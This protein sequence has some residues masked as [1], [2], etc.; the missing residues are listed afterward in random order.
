MKIKILERQDHFEAVNIKSWG[1]KYMLY[2]NYNDDIDDIEEYKKFENSV[3]DNFDKDWLGGEV[4]HLVKFKIKDRIYEFVDYYEGDVPTGFFIRLPNG[5]KDEDY[6]ESNVI[7]SVDRLY[8]DLTRDTFGKFENDYDEDDQSYR[9][10]HKDYRFYCSELLYYYITV[11][12]QESLE[13]YFYFIDNNYIP[14]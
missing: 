13:D 12:K 1:L 3:E 11:F 7:I 10:Y 6:D 4:D 9:K 8:E 2:K 5:G 14:K